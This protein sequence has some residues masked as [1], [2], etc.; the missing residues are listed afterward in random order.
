MILCI[1]SNVQ[2][3]RAASMFC[4]EG[5]DPRLILYL[6]GSNKPNNKLR[7]AV[8]N[9]CLESTNSALCDVTNIWLSWCVHNT[10]RLP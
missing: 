8:R 2:Y 9:K 6:L 7:K 10:F 1:H 3:E 4:F 5:L